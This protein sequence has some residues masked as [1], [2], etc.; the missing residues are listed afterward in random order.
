MPRSFL[1]PLSQV[2][3]LYSIG[4]PLFS[5]S[6]YGP[7]VAM[8]IRENSKTVSRLPPEPFT[9][10]GTDKVHRARS[11]YNDL[12]QGPGMP[13]PTMHHT[14]VGPLMWRLSTA[15][16]WGRPQKVV[17]FMVETP[18]TYAAVGDSP[19]HSLASSA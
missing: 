15:R 1:P 19:S 3:P 9:L 4:I 12:D 5:G 13:V 14:D 11:R 2:I 6:H 18:R 17:V 10:G 7:S 8:Y 16:D